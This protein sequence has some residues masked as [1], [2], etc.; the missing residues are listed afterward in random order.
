MKLKLISAAALAALSVG[1]FGC[2]SSS[3]TSTKDSGGETPEEE[4]T[5][6][7]APLGE[8]PPGDAPA[9]GLCTPN[10]APTAGTD[11]T[12]HIDDCGAALTGTN[13]TIKVTVKNFEF[14]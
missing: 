11:P 1:M 12:I 13:L 5:P 2:S 14:K 8:T 10:P 6:G 4:V 7:D 3:T 9:G